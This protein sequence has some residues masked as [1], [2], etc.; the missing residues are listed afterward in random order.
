MLQFDDT[1]DDGCFGTWQHDAQ[2][3]VTGRNLLS[4]NHG[5]HVTKALLQQPADAVNCLLKFDSLQFVFIICHELRSSEHW[6]FRL[7]ERII[8][9]CFDDADHLGNRLD[10]Y[11]VCVVSDHDRADAHQK[12]REHCDNEA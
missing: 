11:N 12:A 7:P 4:Y 3:S 9:E 10:D 1:E 2:G 6:L 5:A 8:S